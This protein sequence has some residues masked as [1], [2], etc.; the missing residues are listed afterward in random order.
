MSA[1]HP[2]SCL[3]CS[4]SFATPTLH[5]DHYSSELH[6]YN[7][8]RKVAKLPPV[9]REVWEEKL[10]AGAKL[11]KEEAEK[12]EEWYCKACSKSFSSINAHRNHLESK[13]HRDNVFKSFSADSISKSQSQS[14][15]SKSASNSLS[16]ESTDVAAVTQS[17]ASASLAT[18]PGG[19]TM[20]ALV[21]SRLAS[22]PPLPKGT[23]L[24]C[25]SST[26]FAS[27]DELTTHMQRKHGFFIPDSEYLVD[28]PGLLGRLGE[29]VGTWNV[30]VCCG[31]GY[32]GEVVIEQVEEE[33]SEKKKVRERDGLDAVRKHMD[34]KRHC[35]LPWDTEEERLDYADF[36]DYRPSYPDYKPPKKKEEEWEDTE[37]VED[38]EGEVV[39]V[40]ASEDEESEEEEDEDFE[41]TIPISYGST[42]YEL[43]LPSG[44]RI[45]HR[46]LRKIYAQNLAPHLIK[47]AAS[48]S[49]PSKDS[50]L[51]DRL[52]ES[53]TTGKSLA[54]SRQGLVA[55]KGGGG[56]FG[57]GGELVKARNAGEAKEAGRH[58]REYRDQRK[59][60]EQQFVTGMKNNNQKHFRD[61][62][63]Q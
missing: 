11:E 22:H 32:G 45:G 62:L 55:A 58:I 35:R 8:K 43:I 38:D 44:I 12:K 26:S 61:P 52:A 5:R 24:F 41:N 20:D 48:R 57:R 2:F 31:K 25:H 6:R 14:T 30:C 36:Y 16:E 7:A 54:L 27:L 28:L 37:D 34:A 50:Q 21:K 49:G 3:T 15:I 17:L 1:T 53:V 60:S 18:T 56:K 47:S 4:L 63:L 19:D 23:C 29:L 10:G 40:S 9:T 42:P 13:K 46:S 39:E 33:G 51:V 59:I